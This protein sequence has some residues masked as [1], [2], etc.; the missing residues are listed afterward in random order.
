MNVPPSLLSAAGLRSADQRTE[1]PGQARRAGS[2]HGDSES[3]GHGCHP[4]PGETASLTWSSLPSLRPEALV[5]SPWLTVTKCQLRLSD[6]SDGTVLN[7]D[8]AAQAD[9]NHKNMKSEYWGT[10]AASASAT[11]PVLHKLICKPGHSK[12]VHKTVQYMQ[13]C[14]IYIF[15]C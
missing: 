8:L 3:G 10:D 13:N 5:Q 2:D 7:P 9:S 4:G 6:V 12:I 1:T 15:I 14:A 11:V